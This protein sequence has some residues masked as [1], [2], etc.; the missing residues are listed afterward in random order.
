M[1]HQ[2]E[3]I[4]SI[5][6]FPLAMDVQFPKFSKSQGHSKLILVAISSIEWSNPGALLS[7]FFGHYKMEKRM[8]GVVPEGF[9]ICLL[10]FSLWARS[11][12]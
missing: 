7:H 4:L 8:F 12:L 9:I 11:T 6:I 10:H 3:L 1:T 2:Y 5:R